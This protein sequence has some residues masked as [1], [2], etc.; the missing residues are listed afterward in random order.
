[1][2]KLLMKLTQMVMTMMLMSVNQNW[3]LFLQLWRLCS[4]PS[5]EVPFSKI[6]IRSDNLSVNRLIVVLLE[7]FLF[8][9]AGYIGSLFK[10]IIC[11]IHHHIAI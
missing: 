4:D 5:P 8:H 6:I 9:F 11:V 10:V 7:I 1:M 3:Y 2:V